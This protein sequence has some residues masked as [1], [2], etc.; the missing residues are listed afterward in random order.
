MMQKNNVILL[1]A[2]CAMSG[3]AL[4]AAC[5]NANLSD[6]Q[7]SANKS[8]NQLTLCGSGSAE[9][10]NSVTIE[11]DVTITD[12]GYW[13]LAPSG[14]IS[15]DL[16]IVNLGT[17][18]TTYRGI[19]LG[20]SETQ[21]LEK[22]DNRGIIEGKGTNGIDVQEKGS[23]SVLNN[24]GAIRSSD[25]YTAAIRLNGGSIVTLNNFGTIK[26]DFSA[27]PGFADIIFSGGSSIGT[28]V[29]AQGGSDPLD[30]ANKLPLTYE[31]FIDSNDNSQYGKL[32]ATGVS[33]SKMNFG[34]YGDPVISTTSFTDVLSGL[35]SS[36]LANTSGEFRGATWELRND[37]SNAWDLV[38]LS[39]P[40]Y[41]SLSVLG[42]STTQRNSRAYGAATVID[43]SEG[44]RQLFVDAKL[45]ADDEI[46]AAASQT[47]PLFSGSAVAASSSALSGINRVIQAR[48]ESNRGMSAG[49]GFAMDAKNVWLK[50]FGSW[51]KQGDRDGLSGFDADIAGLAVGVDGAVSATWQIGGALAYAKSTSK[52][53]STVAAQSAD[54]DIHQVVAYASKA[55]GEDLE[56]NVQVDAGYNNTRG[57][58]NIGFTNTVAASKY[59][60]RS[61]HV[62]LGLAKVYPVVGN[63]AITASLRGDYTRIKD[64]AYSESGAGLL[65]L[66]VKE[67]VAEDTVISADVK[68]VKPINEQTHL[69]VRAGLGYGLN[70][71]ALML[72]SSFAGASSSVF[73]TQGIRQDPL[74]GRLGL[75]ITHVL[76]GGA[77]VIG[78]YDLESR[79][80]GFSNQTV[81][82][83]VR[84]TF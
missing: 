46:S 26:R 15:N 18:S 17:I 54:M 77:E 4:A 69:L 35:T 22:L 28:L 38:F 6:Y 23:I 9:L 32:T 65:N 36:N 29:N 79:Q 51:A 81:S 68:W 70:N 71:D 37:G 64:N 84:W 48:L 21:L 78:N 24:Y 61:A 10:P 34:I 50:P 56:L 76:E 20:L 63:G 5:N 73:A 12:S 41:V 53:N 80:S 55:L 60:S 52:S 44:L 27:Q 2:S 67:R 7:I 57:V 39:L 74:I 83:K 42:S 58:R 13:G 59:G 30:V 14:V 31:I 43:N 16:R 72:L 19:T 3:S 33:S 49:D 25:Q 11:P 66:S 82:M 62:G 40:S 45:E 1:V 75:G 47:L 8:A